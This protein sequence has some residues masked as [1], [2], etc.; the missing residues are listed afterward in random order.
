MSGAMRP[1]ELADRFEVTEDTSAIRLKDTNLEIQDV[2]ANGDAYAF[3][4]LNASGGDAFTDINFSID[5]DYKWSVGQGGASGIFYI[6]DYDND[7]TP[8]RAIPVRGTVAMSPAPTVP[9]TAGA[10]G[11]KG[12]FTW[13]ATHF[14]VCV[15]TNTWV[16]A[17]MATW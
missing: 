15:D 5:D 11:I 1:S 16:R 3:L 6:Y 2:D 10:T 17:D 9:A 13:D 4:E 8:L 14:Y 7:E 12:E